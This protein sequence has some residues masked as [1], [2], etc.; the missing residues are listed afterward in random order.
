MNKAK[1]WFVAAAVL[2]G[3]VVSANALAGGWHHG[4]HGHARVGVFIGAPLFYS[5]WYYPYGYY[6]APYYPPV[7]YPSYPSGPTTYVE[8]GQPEAAPAQRSDSNSNYWYYC[9][10][11]KAYYPYVKQCAAGWQKVSPQ[12]PS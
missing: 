2:I 5:P 8:Q 4:G 1:T 12:P 11:A 6:P 7:A 3:S 10:E 9:P